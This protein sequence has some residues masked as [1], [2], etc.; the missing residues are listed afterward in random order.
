MLVIVWVTKN[1]A[2]ECF[3]RQVK[4]LVPVTFAVVSILQPALGFIVGCGTVSLYLIHKEWLFP[5]SR[6]I[7]TDDEEMY[8]YRQ[9]VACTGFL[10][11]VDKK[12]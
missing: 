10:Y 6:D 12:L 11:R 7:N 4:L 5:S 2:P 3:E 9:A 8:L 1:L